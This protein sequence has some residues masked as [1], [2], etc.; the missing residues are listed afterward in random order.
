MV[1]AQLFF[2]RCCDVMG[3]VTAGCC[4]HFLL[5]LWCQNQ[6]PHLCC[7]GLENIWT[8]MNA[9]PDQGTDTQN[10]T[11]FLAQVRA[12][13]ITK[14]T[15]YGEE[16][17]NLCGLNYSEVINPTKSGSHWCSQPSCAEAHPAA[18]SHPQVILVTRCHERLH[19][20]PSPGVLQHRNIKKTTKTTDHQ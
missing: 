20:S 18:E 9:N 8:G 13:L 12:V 15:R 11:T 19:L 16:E 14:V 5:D 10:V 17:R 4:N 1:R 3:A 6:R 7:A 2:E